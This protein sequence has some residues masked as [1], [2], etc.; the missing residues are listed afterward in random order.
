[1]LHGSARRGCIIHSDT[2]R[3]E[4]II[5]ITRINLWCLFPLTYNFIYVCSISVPGDDLLPLCVSG[6]AGNPVIQHSTLPLPSQGPLSCHTHL[7][8]TLGVASAPFLH[9]QYLVISLYL[10]SLP[11]SHLGNKRKLSV[12]SLHYSLLSQTWRNIVY[13]FT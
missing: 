12:M 1:M 13:L 10:S 9:F 7:P 2:I 6:D 5:V 4:L 3:Y 11:L 8:A